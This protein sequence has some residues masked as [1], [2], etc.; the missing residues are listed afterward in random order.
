MSAW[1]V[2]TSMILPLPSSPHCIPIKIVFAIEIRYGQKISQHF[3]SKVL[4]LPTDDK[5]AMSPRNKFRG[6]AALSSVISC[7]PNR[8][9]TPTLYLLALFRSC[10]SDPAVEREESLTIPSEIRQAEIQSCL[11]T[12]N[13]TRD[14]Y[15]ALSPDGCHGSAA[16]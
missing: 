15:A 8:G 6:S 7:W 13:I 3:A 2:S 10:H 1:A 14:P 11:A 16:P 12:L 4:G 9:S 5:L